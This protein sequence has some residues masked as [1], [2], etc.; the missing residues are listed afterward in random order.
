MKQTGNHWIGPDG[1]P[2]AYKYVPHYERQ[3]EVNGQ[4][5]ARLAL[6]ME[7]RIKSS[8]SEFAR[9]CDE[10]LIRWKANNPNT[11]PKS[12]SFT[13]FDK[14]FRIEVAFQ[15]GRQPYYRVYQAT[16]PNPTLKDYRLVNMDF[17]R[18][19]T[20]SGEY[21]YVPGKLDPP[22]ATLFAPE[23]AIAKQED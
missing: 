5:L 7:E 12:F 4:K 16:K 20:K 23:E 8:R 17:S 11:D 9:L 2:T 6:T 19:D 13:T 18:T 1:S 10:M 3:A 14:E 15:E 22:T 21:L